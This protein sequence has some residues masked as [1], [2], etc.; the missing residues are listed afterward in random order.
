[1]ISDR[2]L[3]ETDWNSPEKNPANFR[4]EYCFHIWLFPVLSCRIRCFPRFFPVGS[5]RIRMRESL[6]RE[7]VVVLLLLVDELL[8][9]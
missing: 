9:D 3:P 7:V 2:F 1:M 8:V 4:L 5:C 6:T